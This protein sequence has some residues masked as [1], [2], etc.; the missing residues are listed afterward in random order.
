MG[1]RVS[2]LEL[3]EKRFDGPIFNWYWQIGRWQLNLSFSNFHSYIYYILCSYVL[4]VIF[5]SLCTLLCTLYFFIFK[6]LDERKLVFY[7]KYQ[8]ALRRPQQRQD[9]MYQTNG[10][11]LNKP[12]EFFLLVVSNKIHH[13]HAV[14]RQQS[15]VAVKTT[16]RRLTG[17]RWSPRRS[18]SLRR[19]H[20]PTRLDTRS[21]RLRPPALRRSDPDGSFL[22]PLGPPVVAVESRRGPASAKT[23]ATRWAWPRAPQTCSPYPAGVAYSGHTSD[24]LRAWPT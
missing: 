2:T 11:N 16:R 14:W 22:R 13:I 20:W 9:D 18:P 3:W 21:N 6:C 23:G 7:I 4:F 8:Q 24:G 17:L 10:G 1:F 12:K 19:L 15:S 5:I